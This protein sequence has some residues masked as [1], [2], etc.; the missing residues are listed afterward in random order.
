M[1]RLLARAAKLLGIFSRS[2]ASAPPGKSTHTSGNGGGAGARAE[3]PPAAADSIATAAASES[4]AVIQ[5]LCERCDSVAQLASWSRISRAWRAVVDVQMWVLVLA[6][7]AEGLQPRRHHPAA[8]W[9][10]AK[11]MAALSL[12]RRTRRGDGGILESGYRSAATRGYGPLAEAEDAV[13]ASPLELGAPAPADITAA[14]GRELGMMALWQR[15]YPQQRGSACQRQ[16]LTLVVRDGVRHGKRGCTR[17]LVK[18]LAC[19]EVSDR[20]C[21]S[22]LLDRTVLE[23]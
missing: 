16:R 11:A 8:G 4:L 14:G 7:E 3:E 13:V 12:L 5:S 15:S 18:E 21:C 19:V 23:V 22:A 9:P 10:L 1:S 6:R 2:P 20:G 17:A